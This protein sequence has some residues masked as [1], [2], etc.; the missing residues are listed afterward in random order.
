MIAK[1]KTN[2]R[3]ILKVGRDHS[4]SN[5]LILMFPS[6][7]PLKN[8]FISFNRYLVT[9]YITNRNARLGM[10]LRMLIPNELS[11]VKKKPNREFETLLVHGNNPKIYWT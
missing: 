6:S 8:N 9:K 11:G 7:S 5:P 3:N 1:I 2:I 4:D 10:K